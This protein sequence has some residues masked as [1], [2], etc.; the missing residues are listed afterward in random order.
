LEKESSR[1]STLVSFNFVLFICRVA[2]F[3]AV[4]HVNRVLRGRKEDN[5][6]GVE[7]RVGDN[8]QRKT[9]FKLGG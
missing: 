9:S 5:I 3:A 2:G 8:P 6:H 1:K 4:R 7:L